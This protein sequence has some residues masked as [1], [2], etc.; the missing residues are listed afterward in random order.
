MPVNTIPQVTHFDHEIDITSRLCPM[1]FVH[2]RLALDRLQPGQVLRVRL[3][4]QEPRTS[5][6]R[7]TME[8]GHSILSMQD[9]PDG[10]TVLM[11]QKSPPQK[12]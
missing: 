10:T 6:P 11:I 12:T 8:L 7:S 9:E 2:T 3:K 4:G 1:T 5:V